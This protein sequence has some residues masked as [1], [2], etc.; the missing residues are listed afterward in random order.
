MQECSAHDGCWINVSPSPPFSPVIVYSFENGNDDNFL[1]LFLGLKQKVYVTSTSGVW[2]LL[3]W[4]FKQL[5]RDPASCWH[6]LQVR[7]A[8]AER[9]SLTGFLLPG[10]PFPGSC[11]AHPFHGCLLSSLTFAHG[12][13]L[14][15]WV[16]VCMDGCPASSGPQS[17][18]WETGQ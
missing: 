1:E 11:L 4:A 8:W 6:R 12:C 9:G 2:A 15:G 17:P 3:M 16:L 7:R 13:E 14:E 5:A 10:A 18:S